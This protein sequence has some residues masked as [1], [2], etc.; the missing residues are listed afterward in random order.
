MYRPGLC[1]ASLL[2]ALLVPVLTGCTAQRELIDQQQRTI[3]SLQTENAI[4][5][6]RTT[7]LTDSLQFY[8][9]VE[10]GAYYREMRTLR[11]RL[12]RLVYES[13]L[14]RDRGITVATLQADALFEPASA[15]LR[16]HGIDQLA[17]IVKDLQST[18]PE[19]QIRIEG[20]ADNVP[21]G[22]S[23][24]EKYPSNWE[25]SAA[26]AAAVARHLI[27]T[28][29]IDP[30]RFGVLGFGST[31]PVADNDTAAGRWLNRR[32]RIAVLPEPSN[33]DRPTEL[34]W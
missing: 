26:R 18:Y 14:L 7:V 30:D 4:L 28:H 1:V 11:D 24:Q 29:E 6:D 34:S 3:D 32:V 17:E 5:Q 12:T 31:R 9:D 22:P 19:R 8:D 27:D 23:L 15:I 20:H 13:S 21:L 33:A 16:P 2:F 10:S 25:L